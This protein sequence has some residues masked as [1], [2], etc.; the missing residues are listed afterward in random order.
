MSLSSKKVGRVERLAKMGKG[1]KG[2]KT[3]AKAA[4]NAVNDDDALLDAAITENRKIREEQEAAR[5][6]A[7]KRLTMQEAVAK[8]DGVMAFN[9]ISIR[10]GKKDVFLMPSGAVEFHADAADARAALERAQAALLG[11]RPAYIAAAVDQRERLLRRGGSR[12]RQNPRHERV[13][14]D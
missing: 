5:R 7:A 2:N 14:E 13:L 11:D 9:V 12:T 3:R 8:L 1:G 6:N 4:V 10:D